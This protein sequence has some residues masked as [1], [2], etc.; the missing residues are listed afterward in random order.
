MNDLIK[1]IDPHVHLF[2]LSLGNYSWLKTTNPPYWPDKTKIQQNFT[3]Q[4][5]TIAAPLT[6]AGF[7]HLEAGFDNQ[8]PWREIAWLESNCKKPFRSIAF[9]DITLGSDEFIRH[10]QQLI[11]FQSCVGVRFILSTENLTAL[12]KPHVTQNFKILAQH[13]LIFELQ[14]SFYDTELL[15][16]FLV[17]INLCPTLQVIINHTGFPEEN[18]IQHWLSTLKK[19]SKYQQIAIKCSGW[20][21][22]N[23]LYTFN[24]LIKII[25]HC[26][27]AFGENRVMLASNFPLVLFSQTYNKYWQT[28][29]QAVTFSDQKMNKNLLTQAVAEK[30]FYQNSY[31]Y[32]LFNLNS[33]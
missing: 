33:G 16:A 20:E 3:E 1:I 25:N 18:N 5:L 29:A 28:L 4:N 9:I 31:N 24:W 2:D 23:R 13:Q 7:V 32:Y 21:M 26:I 19:L 22:T 27:E 30:I 10:V 8:Q 12:A 6:L 11:S 15:N 14:L 17:I